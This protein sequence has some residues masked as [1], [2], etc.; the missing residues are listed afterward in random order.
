MPVNCSKSRSGRNPQRCP[1][2]TCPPA[3]CSKSRSGRNPQRPPRTE[4]HVGDCSKSRSGRNPQ[5]IPP[6]I[7]QPS[8]CSKSRSGRKPRAG[9]SRGHRQQAQGPEVPRRR[10]GGRRTQIATVNLDSLEHENPRPVGCL[11]LEAR[12][13][14]HDLGITGREC[15]DRR[16]DDPPASAGCAMTARPRSFRIRRASR[17]TASAT[18]ATGPPSGRSC[19]TASARCIPDTI[20]FYDLT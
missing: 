13:R 16:Q 12:S 18:C 6:G 17:C 8:D 14:L 4:H 19:S 20:A 3:H 5:H 11:C 7:V 15:A 9:R 10:S 1:L 2:M